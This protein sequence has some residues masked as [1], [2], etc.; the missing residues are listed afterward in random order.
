MEGYLKLKDIMDE[1]VALL[2]KLIAF[3]EQ[4]LEAVK[5]AKIEDLDRFLKDEQVHLLQ[6]KGLDAKREKLQA[7]LGYE[8]LTYKQIISKTE[9]ELRQ[10]L[11]DS[12]VVLESKTNQFKGLIRTINSCIDVKLHTIEATLERFGAEPAAK[13]AP[14]AGIYD[15]INTDT[16]APPSG[17]RFKSTKA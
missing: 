2:D 8:G 7:E 12:F 13:P 6:F 14:Q 11:E 9:G 15:K 3:E 17:L 4:K 5:Q 16:S 10:Q 1:Y